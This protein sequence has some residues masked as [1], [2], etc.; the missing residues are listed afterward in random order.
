M[1]SFAHGTAATRGEGEPSRRPG[2]PAR[3]TSHG[4]ERRFQCVGVPVAA[5]V[6]PG[7]AGAVA[8]GR[9]GARRRPPRPRARPRRATPRARRPRAARG[10]AVRAA[11]A[12]RSAPR[13]AGDAPRPTESSGRGPALVATAA[14]ARAREHAVPVVAYA[15]ASRVRARARAGRTFPPASLPL[16]DLFGHVRV[17]GIVLPYRS[18]LR[19]GR[20]PV[21]GDGQNDEG[22]PGEHLWRA[23]SRHGGVKL[24]V[25]PVAKRT[26]PG[27]SRT[28]SRAVRPTSRKGGLKGGNTWRELLIIARLC[29]RI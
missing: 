16:D 7:P 6:E 25:T 18:L 24:A 13:A 4:P 10:I 17:D 21:G 22:E 29:S 9:V 26:R 1:D 3:A 12:S 27:P 8:R 23:A 15:T 14:G 28:S 11:R 19:L 20:P 5:S 2:T